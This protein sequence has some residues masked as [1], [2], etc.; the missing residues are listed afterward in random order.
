[1]AALEALHGVIGGPLLPRPISLS[2]GELGGYRVG[3]TSSI[4]RMSRVA[5]VARLMADVVTSSGCT[6]CRPGAVLGRCVSCLAQHCTRRPAAAAA[7]ES[8][9]HGRAVRG[10]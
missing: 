3:T 8:A 10:A 4:L 6:T 5:S 1:M 9:K 2:I 7:R